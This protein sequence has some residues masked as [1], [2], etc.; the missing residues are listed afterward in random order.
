MTGKQTAVRVPAT[1]PQ[2]RGDLHHHP[3]IRS[4]WLCLWQPGVVATLGLQETCLLNLLTISGL[5]RLRT[6][7]EVPPEK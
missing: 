2:Q 4:L 6:W 3:T 5:E 1:D 7:E